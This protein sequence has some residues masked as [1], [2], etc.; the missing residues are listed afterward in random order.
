[1]GMLMPVQYTWLLTGL[2]HP[3]LDH[4]P[5]RCSLLEAYKQTLDILPQ[6]N[7]VSNHAHIRFT[8]DEVKIVGFLTGDAAVA[9]TEA[10]EYGL[11]LE[12]LEAG[13]AVA[14]NHILPLWAP[15][16]DLR[17]LHPQLADDLY[18]VSNAL[19]RTAS[20]QNF[21]SAF[22]PASADEIHSLDAQA[23][24][25]HH[26]ALEYGAL[27]ARNR[28]LDGFEAF[29]RP[30]IVSQLTGACT[31]GPVVIISI[32]PS[33]CDALV[34]CHPD[35]IKHIPLPLF[36]YERAGELEENSSLD[37]HVVARPTT[38]QIKSWMLPNK[39]LVLIHGRAYSWPG[40]RCT[41]SLR[42]SGICLSSP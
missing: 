36:S 29:M 30:R 9:E 20:D 26:H 6:C 16:D 25:S 14:S 11:A 33:R 15:L 18:R 35:M 10:G 41:Q 3:D 7:W 37:I 32:Y 12:W 23:Q 17:R 34:L 40:T 21:L 2:L 8:S 19:H 4:T 24:L 28:S 13:R 5:A 42:I 31:N 38:N 1:M 39:I 27:I 22:F